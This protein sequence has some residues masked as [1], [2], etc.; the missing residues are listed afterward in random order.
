MANFP[1]RPFTVPAASRAADRR[2]AGTAAT[3]LVH[4][5]LILGWQLARTLPPAQP[6]GE[7]SA[8]QW[9]RLPALAP[10]TRAAPS[11]SPEDARQRSRPAPGRPTQPGLATIPAAPA[12][13]PAS[14]SEAPGPSA[15]P[16]S[17]DKAPISPGAETIMES[18]RRSVGSIDRELRKNS[19]PLITA[20]LDSPQIRMRNGMEQAH[21]MAPPR[22]WEAPKIEELVNNTGDGARRTR[23]ITGN[24]T[25]CLTERS[26]A[27]SIDMIEKHGKLRFTSCPQDEEP[28]KQQAWRTAR[29]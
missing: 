17:A 18:A 11:A 27:T 8:I 9:L 1:I 2:L 16:V 24:G 13:A 21:A 15:A 3:V 14:E 20:P 29:D 28:A 19:R 4:A 26:A 12:P 5:A 23:V 22:L 7:S 10:L 25:Y 6:D